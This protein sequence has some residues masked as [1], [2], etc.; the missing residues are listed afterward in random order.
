V[1]SFA[2]RDGEIVEAGGLR[3]AGVN[4]LVCS[5]GECCISPGRFRRAVSRVGAVDLFV[6]HQPPS[7]PYPE[8]GATRRRN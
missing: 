7:V 4:G 8:L 2:L 6:T 5:G 1:R 3:I